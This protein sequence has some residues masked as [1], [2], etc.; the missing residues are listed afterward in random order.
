M[1]KKKHLRGFKLYCKFKKI[2]ILWCCL[3]PT[4][5]K[6]LYDCS[7]TLDKRNTKHYLLEGYFSNLKVLKKCFKIIHQRLKT[8]FKQLILLKKITH[9]SRDILVIE[10]YIY[11]LK[12]TYAR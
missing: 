5:Q 6:P 11:L 3:P 4:A 1:T 8:S 10:V 12:L 7:T 2:H 9:G